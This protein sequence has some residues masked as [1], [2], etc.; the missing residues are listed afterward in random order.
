[1]KVLK[2]FYYTVTFLAAVAVLGVTGFETYLHWG[3][4]TGNVTE[5]HRHHKVEK[6]AVPDCCSDC[7]KD[8]KE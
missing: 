2:A 3:V 4:L 5:L 6:P 7:C 8:K 1:M